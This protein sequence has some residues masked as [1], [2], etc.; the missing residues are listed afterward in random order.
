MTPCTHLSRF[1]RD[2][3][4]EKGDQTPI[5]WVHRDER[6][7]EKLATPDVSVADLIGDVD[8]IKGRYPQTALFGRARYSLSG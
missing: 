6:Y 7:T 8:P 3:V 1:A 4:N 2:L 5:A